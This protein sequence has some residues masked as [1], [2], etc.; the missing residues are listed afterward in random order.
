F[1]IITADLQTR[2]VTRPVNNAIE[3]ENDA[4]WAA[5]LG[6]SPG[7]FG[8][9]VEATLKPLRDKD[10]PESRAASF[11]MPYSTAAYTA[12]LELVAEYNDNDDWPADFN[13]S[14][15]ALPPIL[16]ILPKNIDTKM[17]SHSELAGTQLISH[18][19]T[20]AVWC[21]WT[22]L[23]GGGYTR[24]AKDFF[25][26][27][28]SK[29]RPFLLSPLK[30]HA[31]LVVAALY[32]AQNLVIASP[33]QPTAVSQ[34]CMDFCLPPDNKGMPFVGPSLVADSKNLTTNGFVAWAVNMAEETK[35]HKGCY[36]DAVYVLSGGKH[37]RIASNAA[38]YPN[39]FSFRGDCTLLTL[40]AILY[41]NTNY[42]GQ[43]WPQ[44]KQSAEA[45]TSI[46]KAGAV[47]PNGVLSVRDRRWKGFPHGT[48]D[49][50]LDKARDYFFESEEQWSRLVEFKHGIDPMDV[51]T[52]NL[53]CVGAS[54]GKK[55]LIDTAEE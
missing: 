13:L 18:P 50:D 43:Y 37:S 22:N 49:F 54:S 29:L 40:H 7:N 39:S 35:K 41:K 8:V 20:L 48:D 31:A 25:A 24:E 42:W 28:D 46:F 14:V 30:T 19:G 44:P 10:H 53:F 52:A 3:S 45:L 21:T 51:F 9:V 2:V 1:R 11:Y 55:G 26:H 36:L 16:P 17:I 38:A 5:V 6:G 4:L 32:N 27:V 15:I 33:E 23:D 34:M 12:C 47:G